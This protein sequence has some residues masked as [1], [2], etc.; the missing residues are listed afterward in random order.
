V[1]LAEGKVTFR[2]KDYAHGGQQK[3]MTL[4]LTSS[5]TIPPAHRSACFVRIRSSFLANADEKRCCQSAN[6]CSA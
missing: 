3:L 6:N 1:N 4:T 5:A 2:W